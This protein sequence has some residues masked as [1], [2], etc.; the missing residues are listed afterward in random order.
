MMGMELP[1]FLGNNPAILIHNEGQEVEKWYIAIGKSLYLSPSER[2]NP[3]AHNRYREWRSLYMQPPDDDS[4]E[5][6]TV[7]LTNS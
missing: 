5:P 7:V 4:P 3:Y 2:R 6:I 1:S